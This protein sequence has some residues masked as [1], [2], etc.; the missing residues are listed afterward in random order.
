MADISLTASMRSNLLSLQNTQ[1][2]MDATQNRLSTGKKVNSAID[3]PSS[4]YAS[5][6]LTNRA[7]DLSALL[8]SMG[9]AIQT[10]KAAN[11]GIESITSFA[12]QAKAIA[13]SARDIPSNYDKYSITSKEVGESELAADDTIIIDSRE[14]MSKF[15][16]S[17]A[18]TDANKSFDVYV[19]GEAKTITLADTTFADADAAA[20]DATAK[21]QAL[22]L[23]VEKGET[24]GEIVVRS[25]DASNIYWINGDDGIGEDASAAAVIKLVDADTENSAALSAKITAGVGTKATVDVDGDTISIM[26]E[27]KEFIVAVTAAYKLGISGDRAAGNAK[28]PVEQRISYAKQF[29]DILIQIDELAQ[30]SGYKGVNLLQDNDLKVIFNEYR[31]SELIVQGTDASSRGLKLSNSIDSW[32]KDADLE[33]SIQQ[34]ENAINT[35]RTMASEFGTNYSIIQSREEFTENIVNV[36]EEGSDKLV[37]A[38][39]NEESANMLA[40][41]TRQQLAINSLSLASQASQSVL[42]LFG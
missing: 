28:A 6:S 29:D 40:L 33:A 35:L 37:L 5:Q 9:Q 7:S 3:N 22:G 15:S 27:G 31:T 20:A 12:Q 21:L 25:K 38:D 41:Q 19:N 2:L 23:V 16:M 4:Y 39:M 36:L 32:Q 14:D 8:D 30:D 18:T 11:E 1:S 10:I 17:F 34:I 42:K 26:S 24:A 13:S